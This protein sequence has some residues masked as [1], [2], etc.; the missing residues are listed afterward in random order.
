MNPE[1]T[2]TKLPESIDAKKIA[3]TEMMHG[4]YRHYSICPV[5][6]NNEHVFMNKHPYCITI[7]DRHDR[8]GMEP[9]TARYGYQKGLPFWQRLST[10]K[11]YWCISHFIAKNV[12]ASGI[13]QNILYL[14]YQKGL[15]TL[16]GM[17]NCYGQMRF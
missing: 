17:E 14:N 6:G 1:I 3:D 11:H 9:K 13:L 7:G 10:D 8:I 12:V 15:K 4:I 2:I 16:C 5:C